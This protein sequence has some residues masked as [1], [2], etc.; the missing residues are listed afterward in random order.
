M[1]QKGKNL[2]ALRVC[3]AS[4]KLTWG[5]QRRAQR[6]A[7]TFRK[8][9][10]AGSEVGQTPAMTWKDKNVTVCGGI[11]ETPV[12]AWFK[13]LCLLRLVLLLFSI[14]SQEIATLGLLQ[15]VCLKLGSTCRRAKVT[16]F[17]VYMIEKNKIRDD[18]AQTTKRYYLTM[19]G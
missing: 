15:Y 9:S 7:V 17:S 13:M 8:S 4:R 14:V 2:P 1:W 18:I 10:P 5:Q 11:W 19:A 3:T 16:R 12:T 6:H